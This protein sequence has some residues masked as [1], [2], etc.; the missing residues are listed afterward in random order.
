[1]LQDDALERLLE[2]AGGD[3]RRSITLLQFS[4]ALVEEQRAF[5]STSGLADDRAENLQSI[6]V[7]HVDRVVGHSVLPKAIQD[8][9]WAQ[10]TSP[11]DDVVAPMGV[12][13]PFGGAGLYEDQF[14]AAGGAGGQFGA[15]GGAGG[16]FGGAAPRSSQFGGAAAPR[17]S[18]FGGAAPRRAG[19]KKQL[20]A[21]IL[22]SASRLIQMAHP[23]QSVTAAILSSMTKTSELSDYQLGKMTLLLSEVEGMAAE[24]TPD[25]LT[26]VY[27][28]M[29]AQQLARSPETWDM[30]KKHEDDYMLY[31]IGRKD[32]YDKE[33][34]WGAYPWL[35]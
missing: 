7:E 26:M 12:A 6:T 27:L 24:G 19:P 35:S 14:G 8:E 33:E 28:L 2:V 17:S 22:D 18:Q 32:Q 16:Q 9:L 31:S 3:A 20:G 13:T 10:I 25:E 34:R 15:A 1:M 4:A 29:A 21:T 11:F 23:V 5:A 30:Q